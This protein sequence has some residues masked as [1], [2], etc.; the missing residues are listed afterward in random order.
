MK[1]TLGGVFVKPTCVY[2]QSAHMY[3][4]L[5]VCMSYV[6]LSVCMY[7]ICITFCLSVCMYS[8]QKRKLN[9]SGIVK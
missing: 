9:G 8:A 1:G 3:H 4:F 6:S 7:V 5:S 2:A